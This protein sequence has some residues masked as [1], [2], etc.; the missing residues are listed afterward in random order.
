VMYS[1]LGSSMRRSYPMTGMPA[2]L[3]FATAG[4]TAWGSCASTI[5][6]LAPF[7]I[8][9]SMSVACCSLLRLAS[10]SIY[11]P[12]APSTVFLMFGLSCAAQRGCWKLFHDTPTVQPAPPEPAAA[13]DD[14][15]LAPALAA[16]LLPLLLQAAAMIATVPMSSPNRR[17]IPVSPPV[18]PLLPSRKWRRCPA[19]LPPFCLEKRCRYARRV[20]V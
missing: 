16:G 5:R 11:V 9:V 3:A 14:P 10:A 17:F 18:E 1:V 19:R 2:A 12:P 15:A 6:T 13:A 8:M 7:E 4:S 20:D